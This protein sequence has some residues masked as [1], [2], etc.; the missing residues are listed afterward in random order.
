[1]FVR[2]R[3]ERGSGVPVCSSGNC[4]I[5]GRISTGTVIDLDCNLVRNN[6]ESQ[7]GELYIDQVRQTVISL[8]KLLVGAGTNFTAL[9]PPE[10]LSLSA[11]ACNH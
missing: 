1:M 6:S 11:L 4:D 5:S 3:A 9:A 7:G 8:L 10:S 2:W